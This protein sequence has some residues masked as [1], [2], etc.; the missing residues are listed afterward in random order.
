ME[1]ECKAILKQYEERLERFILGD[2]L[3]WKQKLGK[4]GSGNS[5][6]FKVEEGLA[7]LFKTEL[8]FLRETERVKMEIFNKY[9]WSVQEVYKS[10]DEE[11]NGFIT[12]LQ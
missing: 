11:E 9:E 10:I 5:L 3:V 8:N 1:S 12:Y 7:S 6:H 2:S 4:M